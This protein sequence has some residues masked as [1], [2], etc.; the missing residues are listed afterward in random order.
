MKRAVSFL[1]LVILFFLFAA[2]VLAE[3]YDPEAVGYVQLIKGDVAAVNDDAKVV[4]YNERNKTRELRKKGPVFRGDVILTG[5]DSDVQIFFRD[6]SLMKLGPN[7]A[8]AIAD[9]S[10][11]FDVKQ[12]NGQAIDVLGGAMRFITGTVVESNPDNFKMDTPL[13]I[14]GI[15]GTDVMIQDFDSGGSTP[16]AGLAKYALDN[17]KLD[18]GEFGG[19][20]QAAMAAQDKENV[21]HI[22]GKQKSPVLYTD[23]LGK[24]VVLQMGMQVDVD[25]ATGAGDPYPVSRGTAPVFIKSAPVPDDYLGFYGGPTGGGEASGVTGGDIGGGAGDAPAGNDG[26]GSQSTPSGHGCI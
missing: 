10:Y 19:M 5:D 14:L 15:R 1:S 3:G 24:Q 17:P 9:F 22:T 12:D 21:Q 6:G 8:V 26:G 13:G 4:R 25:R 11:S 7:S 23:D 18:I 16:F 2:P 20:V